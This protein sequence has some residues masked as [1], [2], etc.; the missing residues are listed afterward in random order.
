M[1]TGPLMQTM[2][3]TALSA[4]MISGSA[5]AAPTTCRSESTALKPRPLIELYTSEGCSSCPP[6]DRWLNGQRSNIERGDFSAIAWHVDYWDQLGW[7]D[8]FAIPTASQRQRWL[9]NK[10][11]AQ[12]YT[13]GVFLDGREW[14]RW[15]AGAAPE[16]AKH[17]IPTLALNVE[18]RDGKLHARAEVS[19][20]AEKSTLVLVTQLLNR[21][22][23]VTRGENSGR[24]LHHDFSANAVLQTELAANSAAQTTTADMTFPKGSSAIT[25]FIQNS[26]GAVLQSTQIFLDRC[27]LE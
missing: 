9:A 12:V 14:R 20:L 1:Q 3:R 8:P 6:A 16:S 19:A 2:I 18:R 27:T 5:S 15:S 11:G 4:L 7:N 21:D 25:A 22:S 13:P 26:Q 24:L 10:A 17:A 23:K